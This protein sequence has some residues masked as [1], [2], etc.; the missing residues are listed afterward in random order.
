MKDQIL[1]V[2][3]HDDL[4]SLRDKILRAQADRIILLLADSASL[5]QLDLALCA[6]W[7][8]GVGA[9][10]CSVSPDAEITRA[11]SRAGIASYSTLDGALAGEESHAGTIGAVFERRRFDAPPA[12]RI[13][14]DEELVSAQSSSSLPVA[15][16]TSSGTIASSRT[17]RARTQHISPRLQNGLFLAPLAALAAT[18]LLLVPY[19]KVE[20]NLPA[21]ESARTIPMEA[22]NAVTLAVN[23]VAESAVLSTGRAVVPITYAEGEL[24]LANHSSRVVAIPPGTRFRDPVSG[25]EFETLA[26]VWM[27]PQASVM[28]GIRAVE[29]GS[30]SNLPPGRIREVVGLAVGT[31]EVQQLSST[32]GGRSAARAVVSAADIASLRSQA[33]AQL[34]QNLREAFEQEAAAQAWLIVESSM[35]I[36]SQEESLSARPGAAVDEVHVTL[37][38]E[39]ETLVVLEGVAIDRA[40]EALGIAHNTDALELAGLRVEQVAQG[41]L[42]ILFTVQESESSIPRHLANRLANRTP[43]DAQ[44]LID[45][46]LPYSRTTIH[47]A[48][49]W[50]PFLPAFPMRID[51]QSL[52][53][54]APP[55]GPRAGV[56]GGP[57]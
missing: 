48:P 21:H 17:L 7:A 26:G 27:D 40:R 19:A 29:P 47:L 2:E 20:I 52:P 22:S 31:L 34:I 8:D 3:P 11:S 4:A 39:A 42:H 45:G 50:W 36:R 38:A 41:V 30:Q 32:S 33:Q 10:L 24:S 9:S 6:R 23:A 57:E 55:L 54:A 35:T 51:I 18:A 1:T 12:G 46:L 5:R 43:A 53:A 16:R 14:K 56:G 44:R 28:I 25:M 15:M 37:E 49:A 13:K